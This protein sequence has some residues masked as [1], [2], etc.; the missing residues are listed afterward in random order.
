MNW[1]TKAGGG[2]VKTGPLAAA[3]PGHAAA[4]GE[5]HTLTAVKA[6]R[7]AL[8]NGLRTQGHAST[9]DTLISQTGFDATF[10]VAA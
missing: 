5:E 4:K 6:L 7:A 10:R 1:R 8:G 3:L 9:S 2:Y